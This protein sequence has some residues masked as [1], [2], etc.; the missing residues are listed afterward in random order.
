MFERIRGRRRTPDPLPPETVAAGSVT[1]GAEAV[2]RMDRIRAAWQA[3]DHPR[4]AADGEPTWVAQARAG[5]A[6]DLDAEKQAELLAYLGVEKMDAV[7]T[8]YGC[9][10]ITRQIEALG[11]M[12]ELHDKGIT[13][14]STRG[15]GPIS[16]GTLRHLRDAP[17]PPKQ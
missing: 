7:T 16:S 5:E 9:H 6:V 1:V 17:R 14:R 11:L 12:R 2:E 15:N 13:V 3:I 8:E 4:G 10:S